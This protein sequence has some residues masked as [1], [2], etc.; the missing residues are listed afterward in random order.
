MVAVPPQLLRTLSEVA[1]SGRAA[2]ATIRVVDGGSPGTSG[3]DWASCVSAATTGLVATGLD[4]GTAE[5]TRNAL[6]Q[7]SGPM[8]PV[9]PP[10]DE[11]RARAR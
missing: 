1:E 6:G 7:G 4:E 11:A 9:A 5:R 8:L 3:R 2:R 10:S